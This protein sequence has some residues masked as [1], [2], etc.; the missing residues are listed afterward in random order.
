M[1]ARPAILPVA[2]VAW[3]LGAVLGPAA[4]LAQ[5][6]PGLPAEDQIVLSGSVSVPRGEAVGEVLVF[7]GSVRIDG[8]AKGDVVVFEGPVV[9]T[10]QVNG[11]VI[12]ADGPVT[13]AESARVGGDVSSSAPVGADA[14]ARVRGEVRDGVRFSLEGPLAALGDLLGPV[15]VA[16]SVLLAGLALLALAPRAAD[17]AAEALAS[18]PLSSLAWGVLVVVGV[19]LLSVALAVLVLGLPLGLALLL[20]LGLWWIVGLTLAAWSAGRG[21]VR[22]PHRRLPAFL[23]GWAI[24]AAVGLVPSLNAAVWILASVVGLGAAVVATWRTRE[25]GPRVGRHRR[26]GV[27]ADEAAVGAGTA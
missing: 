6:A 17:A 7:S 21:L 11:S 18:A 10:G 5:E 24:L 8:V 9:V 26:R 25:G 20:S 4:A 23:A 15:A 27:A 13:L 2:A 1:R 12:A 3:G 14:G 16:V 19:P 22:T